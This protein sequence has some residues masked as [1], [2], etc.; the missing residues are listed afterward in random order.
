MPKTKEMHDDLVQN[1]LYSQLRA[2]LYKDAH[3][4]A[5]HKTTSDKNRV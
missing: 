5:L 2:G 3:I 4:F 1:Y